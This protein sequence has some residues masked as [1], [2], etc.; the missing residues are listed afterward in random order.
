M[1]RDSGSRKG[2]KIRQDC[3]LGV[4]QEG[5]RNSSFSVFL[6]HPAS[7]RLADSYL[8]RILVSVHPSTNHVVGDHTRVEGLT[9]LLTEESYPGAAQAPVVFHWEQASHT[10]TR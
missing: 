4:G 9:L 2:V 10:G 5:G 3:G 7:K 1:D 8:A 6:H